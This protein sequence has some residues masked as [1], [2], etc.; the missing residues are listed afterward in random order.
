[1][2]VPGHA[3]LVGETAGQ[4]R[5]R[6]GELLTAKAAGFS[7][8]QASPVTR[9]RPVGPLRVRKRITVLVQEEPHVLPSRARKALGKWTLAC[10]SAFRAA[11]FTL[12]R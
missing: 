9:A 3:A 4:G 5:L 8:I 2:A 6:S 1:M 12:S 10:S 7:K 11:L